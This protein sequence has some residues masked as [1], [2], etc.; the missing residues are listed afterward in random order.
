MKIAVC[1]DEVEFLNSACSMILKWA[2]K[3]DIHVKLYRFDNGDDLINIHKKECMDIIFLDIVMPLFNGIDTAKELR[4]E[5][6]NVPIVFLTSSREFA[7]ESYEVK[8]L[9]YL[10]MSL[11][12]SEKNIKKRMNILQLK[13]RQVSAE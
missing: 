11:R 10:L 9:N 8:A 6:H 2:K 12:I 1:D 4:S 7:V 3:H 13:L 5:N